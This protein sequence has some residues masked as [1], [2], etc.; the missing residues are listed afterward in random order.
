MRLRSGELH[1]M[2]VAVLLSVGEAST[3]PPFK[4]DPGSSALRP[5]RFVGSLLAPCLLIL[6]SA[7]SSLISW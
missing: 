7:R 6:H 4:L 5:F 3:A 2:N 1:D